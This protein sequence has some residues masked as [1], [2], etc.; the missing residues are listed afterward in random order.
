LNTPARSTNRSRIGVLLV[1]GVG[2]PAHSDTLIDFGQAFVGWVARWQQ[3]RS[4]QPAYGHAAL[5]FTPYDGGSD[6]P[7]PYAEFRAPPGPRDPVAPIWVCA[8]AWWASSARPLAFTTMVAFSLRYLWSLL[9]HLILGLG[10]RASR[11]QPGKQSIHDGN[12]WYRLVDVLTSAAHIFAYVLVGVTGYAVLLPIIA[13]AQLPFPP[14]QNFMVVAFFR[15][16][17]QYNA[18]ELLVYCEDEIQAANMRR[19]LAEAVGWLTRPAADGGG[20]CESVTIIA[21]SGGAWVAHGMLTDDTYAWAHARVRKLITLG[22]GLNKIWEIAPPTLERLYRPIEGSI[23]WLDFWGSYDPVPAGWMTPPRIGRR[24]LRSFMRLEPD[25][26]P[27]QCIYK[28]DPLLSRRH[29]MEPRSDPLPPLELAGSPG[30]RAPVPPHARAPTQP[31]SPGLVKMYWPDSVRVI[32]RMD[33]LTDHGGY[34]TNDE[35]VLRRVAAEI[36]ADVYTES[37]FWDPADARL[38]DAIR[39]RRSRVGVLAAARLLGLLGGVLAAKYL[40][41]AAAA[42]VAGIGPIASLLS[43]AREFLLLLTAAARMIA[44]VASIGAWPVLGG[45]WNGVVTLPSGYRARGSGWSSCCC[46]LPARPS[47]ALSG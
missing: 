19:R 40:G 22:C 25:L 8:E 41:G 45:A 33:A 35:E 24:S 14:L 42:Y 12:F 7:I 2:T 37:I 34:F 32:N 3:G 46:G 30:A 17:L 10:H 15:I 44:S 47:R 11:L 1:H 39:T 38:D 28:P 18:S 27:W 36:Q 6:H 16:F 26:R 23:Y 31:P 5:N 29:R 13:A 21:H 9:A 20:D 4:E 43:A